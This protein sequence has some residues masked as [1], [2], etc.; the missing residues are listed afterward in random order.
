M[1]LNAW[2]SMGLVSRHPSVAVVRCLRWLSVAGLLALVGCAPMLPR[3]TPIPDAPIDLAGRCN[4]TEEDG[5]HERAQIDVRANQVQALFWRIDIGRKGHC[6]F[7]LERFRQVQA[8]PSIELIE[9]S[10]GSCKLM[11]WQGQGRVTLA[12]AGCERYCTAGIYEQ[13][14]PVMFDA[15]S[16]ACARVR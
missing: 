6:Q 3:S 7:E 15:S 1:N 12:H 4:Q 14:W 8:R 2:P 13:A 16:G 9:R 5:F 10:G 11:V